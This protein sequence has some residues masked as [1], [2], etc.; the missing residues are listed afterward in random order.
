MQFLQSLPHLA[1]FCVAGAGNREQEKYR[2][3][4]Q[5]IKET[6]LFPSPAELVSYLVRQ[7]FPCPASVRPGAQTPRPPPGPSPF[8]FSGGLRAPLKAR[9]RDERPT[10]KP[11]QQKPSSTLS[12]G[13]RS[14]VPFRMHPGKKTEAD[15]G[16]ATFTQTCSRDHGLVEVPPGHPLRPARRAGPPAL[17]GRCCRS[18]SLLQQRVCAEGLRLGQR[19]SGGLEASV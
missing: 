10:K 11:T 5:D 4:D 16:Q 9:R 19:G 6:S 3:Q 15:G 7:G 13:N 18:S 17:T 12:P 14:T 8:H 2:R 1:H